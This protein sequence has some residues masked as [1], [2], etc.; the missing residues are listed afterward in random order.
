MPLL[1]AKGSQGRE[2]PRALSARSTWSA[3][4]DPDGLIAETSEVD[5]THQLACQDLKRR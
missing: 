3:A 2:H 1:Y 5:N 4:A